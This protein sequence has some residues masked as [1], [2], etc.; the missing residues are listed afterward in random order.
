MNSG[1]SSGIAE[2]QA[3]WAG[4][5]RLRLG[6]IAIGAIVW[7]YALLLASD[8]VVAGRAR[9]DQLASELA[10][11]KPL[12]AQRQWRPVR[13]RSRGSA[14]RSVPPCCAASPEVRPR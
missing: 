3:Q 2:L 7:V 13:R 5:A 11:P 12:A 8:H 4:S 1:L 6:V 10:A 14:I 9:L